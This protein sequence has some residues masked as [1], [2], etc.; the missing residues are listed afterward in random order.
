ME[1]LHVSPNAYWCLVP[2]QSG[3]LRSLSS[4]RHGKGRE[5]V[6]VP[7]GRNKDAMQLRYGT[8]GGPHKV[9]F[10]EGI[11]II[12]EIYQRNLDFLTEEIL[13]LD[14]KLPGSKVAQSR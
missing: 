6:V 10:K 14:I 13:L 11:G 3:S 8:L 9:W 1:S 2:T 4:L 5:E 12:R 7:Y